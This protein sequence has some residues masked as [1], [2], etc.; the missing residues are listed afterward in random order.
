MQKL[1]EKFTNSET[2]MHPITAGSNG[3]YK[4]PRDEELYSNTYHVGTDHKR[5][6]TQN[7][8]K[9]NESRESLDADDNNDDELQTHISKTISNDSAIIKKRLESERSGTH[10]LTIGS[11]NP[12]H[13]KI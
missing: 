5:K 3:F 4:Q 1:F 6:D 12:D 7:F 13:V 10:V 9:L 2:H 11:V 8:S